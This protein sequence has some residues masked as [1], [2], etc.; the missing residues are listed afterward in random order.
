MLCHRRPRA[1]L[2][3]LFCSLAN[4]LGACAGQMSDATIEAR[5]ADDLGLAF[6]PPDA[7]FASA[8]SDYGVSG[9]DGHQSPNRMVTGPPMVG[10]GGVTIA[11]ASGSGV[12]HQPARPPNAGQGGLLPDAAPAV[13]TQAT[14]AS[15]QGPDPTEADTP[16][17]AP[18]RIYGRCV[19]RANANTLND[20]NFVVVRA[21]ARRQW[22]GSRQVC[23]CEAGFSRVG[24]ETVTTSQGEGFPDSVT[25]TYACERNH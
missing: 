25:E 10:L 11:Q 23:G 9:D 13:D 18:G 5:R 4:L 22:S 16:T 8:H 3:S 2:L 12:A 21:P 6:V 17:F 15:K 7:G 14:V 24:V 1:A 19:T 20:R